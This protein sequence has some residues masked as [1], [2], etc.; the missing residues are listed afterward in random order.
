MQHGLACRKI[1]D[2]APG[3]LEQAAN[4]LAYVAVIIDDE[5][6]RGFC[7]LDAFGRRGAR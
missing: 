5:D 7:S 4:S 2:G 6:H 3:G 1:L